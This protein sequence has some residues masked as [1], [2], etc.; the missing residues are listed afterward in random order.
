MTTKKVLICSHCQAVNRVDTE[1][2]AKKAPLCGKCS[3]ALGD[4]DT[5]LNIGEDLLS[6]IIAHSDLPVVIDAYADWC[7]PCKLYGPIF[8]E[9][10]KGNSNRAQFFKVDTEKNQD[11]SI[12]NGIRGIPTTL[13]FHKGVLVVNQSGL[14][15]KDHL[16]SLIP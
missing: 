8:E 9:V 16:L 11:F 3:R 14:L 6:K 1:L 4:Q 13:I 7:G 10:A 2:A 5:V 15:Q 12:K